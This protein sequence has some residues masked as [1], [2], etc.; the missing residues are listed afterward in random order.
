MP[1]GN[2]RQRLRRRMVGLQQLAAC[3]GIPGQ[4]A[5][6]LL[7]AVSERL[8]VPPVG[9][10]VSILDGDDLNDLACFLNLRRRHLA[11]ADVANLPCSCMR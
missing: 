11:Q 9:Q 10:T 3:N 8:L 4:K 2:P 5:D 7:L 6:P 1:R